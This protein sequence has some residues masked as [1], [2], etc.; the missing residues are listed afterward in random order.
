MI[1]VSMVRI[2]LLMSLEHGLVD[3]HISTSWVVVFR[4]ASTPTELS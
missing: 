4:D 2:W 3:I 1:A